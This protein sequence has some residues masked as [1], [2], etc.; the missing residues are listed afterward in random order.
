MASAQVGEIIST[1]WDGGWVHSCTTNYL[2][3]PLRVTCFGQP[4]SYLMV[5][6]AG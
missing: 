4:Y 3:G 2:A 1:P 6:S 5:F